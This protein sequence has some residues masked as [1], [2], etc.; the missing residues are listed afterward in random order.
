MQITAT[1]M[2]DSNF[3]F[4]KLNEYHFEKDPHYLNALYAFS[5]SHPERKELLD[6]C[7]WYLV[8]PTNSG[9][10][11][12]D[13]VMKEV[14]YLWR[15]S[16]FGIFEYD[17]GKSML[18][19]YSPNALNKQYAQILDTMAVP[20]AKPPHCSKPAPSTQVALPWAKLLLESL[21]TIAFASPPAF[22]KADALRLRCLYLYL[23]V[24][25][26]QAPV[27]VPLFPRFASAYRSILVTVVRMVRQESD[28][29]VVNVTHGMGIK[30]LSAGPWDERLLL[31]KTRRV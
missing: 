16:Q 13:C 6:L 25:E 19:G 29:G 18:P 3:G 12:A 27:T 14:V 31:D 21:G 7:P 28:R 5:L 17:Y 1:T 22:E 8:P 11:A 23:R 2:S 26:R 9:T 15:L 10:A 30:N 4:D 20:G 24:C